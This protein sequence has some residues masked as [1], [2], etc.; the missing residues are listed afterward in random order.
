[1]PRGIRGSNPVPVL[2][3]KYHSEF[4]NLIAHPKFVECL[5]HLTSWRARRATKGQAHPYLGRD[6]LRQVALMA[7]YGTFARY[8]TSARPAGQTRTEDSLRKLMVRGMKW[9]LM[10]EFKRAVRA[11]GEDDLVYVALDAPS[12]G[13]GYHDDE[14]ED[15]PAPDMLCDMDPLT[16]LLMKERAETELSLP[17]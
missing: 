6:D 5:D 17:N 10:N 13:A 9:A 14:D 4:E 15:T 3:P 11:G 2:S 16:L 1:M 8:C 12:G 7:A